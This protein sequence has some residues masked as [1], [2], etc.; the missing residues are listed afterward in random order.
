M[1]TED[2]EPI[3]PP[4]AGTTAPDGADRA[5]KDLESLVASLGTARAPANSRVPLGRSAH[6]VVSHL[7]ARDI[8]V[9]R[10]E[11][12][13][14]FS[15]L[16]DALL[17]MD[18]RLSALEAQVPAMV[19]PNHSL[20]DGRPGP[21]RRISDLLDRLLALEAALGAGPESVAVL[22][23]RV[24]QLERGPGPPEAVAPAESAG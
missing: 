15:A 12:R 21:A 11:L 14:A 10:V 22:L 17:G 8:E 9:V 6:R 3:N 16:R 2:G 24:E 23:E 19:D 20:P 13:G 1:E 4:P 7:V 5:L 18:I